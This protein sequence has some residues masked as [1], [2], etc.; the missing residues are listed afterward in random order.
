MQIPPHV[1]EGG[2]DPAPVVRAQG[3][4]RRRARWAG[5]AHAT[6]TGA[7]RRR[8][9]GNGGRAGPAT[10]RALPWA[11]L[12]T[13]AVGRRLRPWR[14][15]NQPSTSQTTA[16][17]TRTRSS[18][19]DVEV[20]GAEVAGAEVAGVEV[21]GVGCTSTAGWTRAR[22]W[23]ATGVSSSA[24]Q[25]AAGWARKKPSE[26]LLSN[27]SE[28]VGFM[29]ALALRRPAGPPVLTPFGPAASGKGSGLARVRSSGGVKP[30]RPGAGATG[31]VPDRSAPGPPPGWRPG[32]GARRCHG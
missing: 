1:E 12:L 25:G 31:A 8:A 3:R 20:A 13:T 9:L 18:G 19:A 10:R 14:R 30:R 7:G 11:A 5:P 17:K 28:R 21:A 29:G 23:R 6:S 2:A 16:I 26:R 24:S 32:R 22:V 4:S 15:A 27:R